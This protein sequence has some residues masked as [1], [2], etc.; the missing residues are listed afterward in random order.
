MVQILLLVLLIASF[1]LHFLAGPVPLDM[2]AF[3]LNV[4]LLL[5]WGITLVWSWRKHRKS[6]FVIYMLSPS[7]TF[8]AIGMLLVFA[9]VIGLTGMRWLTRTWPFFFIMVYFMTVL[10]YVIL[11]GFRA[12]TPTGARLGDIRWRFVFLHVGLLITVI[13]GFA[14]APDNDEMSLKVHKNMAGYH[15]TGLELVDFQLDTYDNGTPSEFRAVMNIDGKEVTLKV[16]HPYSRRFAEDVYLTGYDKAAGADSQYCIVQIV[17]DP[18]KY[19]VTAGI[20]LIITG[21]FML[22]IGGP[23]HRHSNE[24]D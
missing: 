23:R 4:I 5:I 3:P 22:F 14:G 13:S 8:W 16:N 15:G 1:A 11:R 18:W 9:L 21:A 7:A 17:R 6:L 10:S 12:P 2:F 24:M 19:G 20:I